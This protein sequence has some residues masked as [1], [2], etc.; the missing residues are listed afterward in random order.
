MSLNKEEHRAECLSMEGENAV[1][2]CGNRK[3]RVGCFSTQHSINR[4]RPLAHVDK[5]GLS[6]PDITGLLIDAHTPWGDAAG[7]ANI[8]RIQRA[9]ERG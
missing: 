9:G 5:L 4:A 8:I 6:P 2:Y 7:G 1:W 3:V